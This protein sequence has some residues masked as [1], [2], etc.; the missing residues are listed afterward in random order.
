MP[1][2]STISDTIHSPEERT[3]RSVKRRRDIEER[4]ARR[5]RKLWR[6]FRRGQAFMARVLSRDDVAKLKRL[7]WHLLPPEEQFDVA[8]RELRT[9]EQWKWWEH[10]MFALGFTLLREHHRY[11]YT[12]LLIRRAIERIVRHFQKRIPVKAVIKIDMCAREEVERVTRE[13]DPDLYDKHVRYVVN[14]AR[15]QMTYEVD[16]VE[17]PGLLEF[18]LTWLVAYFKEEV[19]KS[20]MFAVTITPVVYEVVKGQEGRFYISRWT[21]ILILKPDPWIRRAM[22]IDYHFIA[23]AREK[24]KEEWASIR[25]Y[26]GEGVMDYDTEITT[27]RGPARTDFLRGRVADIVFRP[28]KVARDLARMLGTPEKWVHIHHCSL[29]FIPQRKTEKSKAYA[30]KARLPPELWFEE[31]TRVDRYALPERRV[32]IPR[33]GRKGFT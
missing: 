3:R 13:R 25:M 30:K 16:L 2:H 7:I 27:G 28:Y 26:A 24:P 8:M 21:P 22:P 17:D 23:L 1:R 33:Y 15:A 29:Y 5:R 18:L 12:S 19:C 6:D 32:P 20:N 31:V 10:V 11:F 4:R 9:I 14:L